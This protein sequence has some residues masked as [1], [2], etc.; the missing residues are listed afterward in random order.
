L[1]INKTHEGI[2]SC[3]S[4]LVCPSKGITH[5]AALL[6]NHTWLQIQLVLIMGEM[7]WR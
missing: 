3:C 4:V 7:W 5:A 2:S 6:V 1:P